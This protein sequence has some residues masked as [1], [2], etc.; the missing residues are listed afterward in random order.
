MNIQIFGTKKCNDTKK[1]YLKQPFLPCSIIVIS[2]RGERTYYKEPKM[3]VHEVIC[4]SCDHR[5]MWMDAEEGPTIETFRSRKTGEIFRTTVCPDCGSR[6]ILLP[7]RMRAVLPGT[8]EDLERMWER[9][10]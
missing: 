10:I 7:D 1:L 4:P 2:Y 3:Q 5:F 8:E 6:M 9:G